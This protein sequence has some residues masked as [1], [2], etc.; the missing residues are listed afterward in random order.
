MKRAI[1]LTLLVFSLT[2]TAGISIGLTE[3]TGGEIVFKSTQFSHKSHVDDM[4]FPCEDCH[5]D[6]FEMRTGAMEKSPDFSMQSIYDGKFCGTCHDGD[7]AFASDENCTSCHSNDGGEEIKY[8]T[9]IFSHSAHIEGM[10]FSC[11]DCHSSPFEMQA[12]EMLTRPD[13]N[14]QSIYDGQFCGSCHDGD[15]AFASDENCTSCH[16]SA[17]G[18]ILFTKPVKAVIFSHDTHSEAFECESCHSGLFEMEALAAQKKPDF[19]MESLYK[20]QYCGAC[21]DGETAFASNTRCATCH[22]GV[23]GFNRTTGNKQSSGH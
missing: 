19:T 11:E 22:I 8:K 14:M 5:N 13:F 3:E 21:H 16:I 9:T 1:F 6:I 7:S 2:I 20:G 18:E 10:G 23:K 4:G 15:S 12:G 17:G